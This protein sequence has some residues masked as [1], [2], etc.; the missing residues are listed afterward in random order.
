MEIHHS[1]IQNN[2][3]GTSKALKYYNVKRERRNN[4]R[5]LITNPPGKYVRGAGDRWPSSRV[6]P[7]PTPIRYSPFPFLLAYTAAVLEREGYDVEIK[8]C[9][10]EDWEREKFLNYVEN[11]SPDLIVMQTST[12]SYYH[13]VETRKMMREISDAPVVAVGLHATAVPFIHLSD[14]F[15]CVIRGEYEY[16]TL[17]IVR[18][19]EKGKK[20]VDIKGVAYVGRDGKPRDSGFAEPVKDLNTLPWPARHLMSMKR[21]CEP[22][23]NGRNVWMMSTRGCAYSCLYCTL[24]V[25]SGRPSFRMR[26][27]QNVCDEME[28]VIREYAPDEIYFDDASISI[29]R[30]HI[31]ALCEEMKRR[32]MDI[33]WSCMVDPGIS[34]DVIEAMAEA[35]CRGI[36]IGIETGDV[37]L[38]AKISRQS[39]NLE[40]V[41]RAIRRCK[42]LKIK[43]LG[44]YM[45]GL[46][47][48]TVEKAQK[49]IDF[50]I[51]LGTNTTQI[52]IVTPFPGTELHRIA[53]E[54]DWLVSEDWRLYDGSHVLLDYP[55]YSRDEIEGIYKKACN[56]WNR[57]IAFR[58]P[59][60]VLHHLYGIYRHQGISVVVDALKWG[61]NKIVKGV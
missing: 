21:Y 45:L 12:P 42:T 47:G 8:D 33:R 61:V 11:Y 20:P 60:T 17:E 39:S 27:P 3:R 53:K 23:A 59:G 52:F 57:H 2:C 29:N 7:D 19:M 1:K 26:D 55:D 41:K 51:S 31:L 58:R 44:T 38:M 4:M 37:D 43:T 32:K 48:E 13:D 24:P 6:N 34:D 54:K 14:G 9:A 16:P 28:H 50:M 46:P 40:D 25:F 30:K 10:E 56:R 35:G 36:K 15:D 18:R 22:F 49:T 5:I